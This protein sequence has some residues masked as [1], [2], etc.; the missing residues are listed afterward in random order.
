MIY[1]DNAATS[2]P[3]PACV[4]RAMLESFCHYG[5]NPGRGGYAMSMRTAEQI[6]RARETAARLFGAPDAGSVAFTGGCTL[7]LN[8]AILG[9]VK[10]G[11][12]VVVSSMEHNAVMRPVSVLQMQG[13][14]VAVASV[15]PGDDGA[16]VASFARLMTSDTAA[17]VCIHAS[18]VTGEVLPI[19]RIGELAEARRIPFVVDAAQSAGMLPLDMTAD[20]V[21]FLCVPG[22]KGL[23]GPLGT[24]MLITSGRYPLRPVI[25]G[26]TGSHSVSLRQPEDWPDMVESGSI[27]VPGVL[28]LAAGMRW[29][30]QQGIASLHRQE[31]ALTRTLYTRL[32]D[33]PGLR[34]YGEL[35]CEQHHVPVLSLNV[36][37]L[38]SEEVASQLD[39]YG[40]AVRAGLHCAPAAHRRLGT[41]TTGTVRLALSAFTTPSE[42]DKVCE[43][44]AVIGKKTLQK[45][46]SMVQ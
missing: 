21:D 44:L 13:C 43:I 42:V 9:L 10:P 26:G 2:W 41:L 34:V 33:L 45:S 28:G 22:H 14:E 27:N 25:T 37:G 20:H 30:E 5:A 1:L 46:E 15:M 35:P 6:Y 38:S 36:I 7:A 39:R 31:L 19:R 23:Y 12:R 32:K 24:G 16:T 3:K 4:R 8:M 18:N 40:V 11:K 29:V 17:V